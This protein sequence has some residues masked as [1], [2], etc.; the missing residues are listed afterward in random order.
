MPE[1]SGA[2]G[3]RKRIHARPGAAKL[4]PEDHV[5]AEADTESLRP[6]SERSSW[7]STFHS[8][9]A[10]PSRTPT[11]TVFQVDTDVFRREITSDA[12]SPRK[13]TKP[14]LARYL[15]GY[16]SIKDASKEPDTFSEPWVELP[17]TFTEY[18]D[19]L[20]SLQSVFSHMTSNPSQPIPLHYNSGIFRIFE[21]YRKIR[22]ESKRL[23]NLLHETFEGYRAAER[24][25]DKAEAEYQAEIRRL[26]LLIARGTSG[27]AG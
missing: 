22:E 8:R 3:W 23:D 17:P 7:R 4:N 27:M 18:V 26:E 5:S 2:G 24:F 13:A 10:T 15:S 19:P 14:K 9:P 6:P 1:K 16:L 25:Y 21:D 12:P 20:V 11:P